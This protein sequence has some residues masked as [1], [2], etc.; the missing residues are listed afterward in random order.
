MDASPDRFDRA[1]V[2]TSSRTRGFTLVELLVV[3]AIIAVLIGLLLPAVQSARESA[4]RSACTNNLR[5]IGLGFA[6][7]ESATKKYPTLGL[8]MGAWGS[9]SWTALKTRDIYGTP[10]TPWTHHVLPYLEEKSLFDM[11]F[12]GEG[13]RDWVQGTR[14]MHTR[15]VKTYV[16]ASRGPRIN[17]AF[18][19]A[20]SGLPSFLLDYASPTRADHGGRMEELCWQSTS[21]DH[22]ERWYGTIVQP[23][24]QVAWG[25][26]STLL[27][28]YT[29]VTAAKVS[30]GLSK[31]LLLA[32]KAVTSR[33][34]LS[35][36]ASDVGFL[37]FEGSPDR[38]WTY[39]R[40]T[41]PRWG[42]KPDS[43]TRVTSQANLDKGKEIG[44]GSAH[45]AGFMA[46]FGDGSVRLLTYNVD[47]AAVLQPLCSRS[48]GDLTAGGD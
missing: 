32:E 1:A 4:R 41:D 6:S 25:G 46:V 26:D 29:A 9:G 7:Y 44:L 20:D 3:I 10:A 39:Q 17:S 21:P 31:T 36:G 22:V 30:D 40:L 28:R 37:H 33:Q 8:Q 13:Y 48:G 45:E 42:P 11:R 2:A 38:I 16:C 34:W 15:L 18:T 43:V 19:V 27:N 12:G 14:S 24:G 23:G 35:G 47:I 5:Q